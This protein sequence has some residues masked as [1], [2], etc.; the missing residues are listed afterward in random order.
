VP[1]SRRILVLAVLLI[2]LHAAVV[3]THSTTAWTYAVSECTQL[4]LDA[5]ALAACIIASRHARATTLPHTFWRLAAMS[6]CLLLSAEAMA[7]FLHWRVEFV[8]LAWIPDIIFVFWFA[9]L[10]MSLLLPPD[11]NSQKFDRLIFLDVFQSALFWLAVDIYFSHPSSGS[12]SS[13]DATLPDV[14][15]A[16]LYNGVIVGAFFLR[17]ISADSKSVR[18]LF[19]RMGMFLF[20]AGAADLFYTLSGESVAPTGWYELVWSSLS[21][22]P[23]AV[24]GSWTQMP[25]EETSIGAPRPS[26][27]L[28]KRQIFPLIYPLLILVMSGF[29]AQHHLEIAALVVV[30]SFLCSSIR[31]FIIQSRQARSER[32]LYHAKEF[33]ES[34]NRTKS[35]FLANMSHEIRTPMNGILGMADLALDTELNAEQRE[36]LTIVK[37]SADSLLQII[38]DILDFSK[39]EAGKMDLEHEPFS[40]RETLGHALKL[41]AVRAH[42][43]G[44]ELACRIAPDVPDSLSGDAGRLRQIVMN[45]VGNALKFT[46]SG[47]IVVRVEV[48]DCSTR[49]VLLNFQISDTGIGIDAAHQKRIFDA[50][51]QADGSTTRK[52]GGTGLGLT[53]SS[54]LVEL[55]G[56]HIRVDSELGK[57]TTF[58]FTTSFQPVDSAAREAEHVSAEALRDMSVLLVDDNETSR[59][60]VGEML[61]VW[62]MV[63]T[64]V[65]SGS[66]ALRR[67]EQAAS[68]GQ[69]YS[70]V[71]LDA[72]IPDVDSFALA[73]AIRKVKSAATT[74]MM[75]NSDQQAIEASRCREMGVAYVVK[76]VAQQELL[77]LVL[78]LLA[79]QTVETSSVTPP[80]R[81]LVR[82]NS[83]KLR[84]LLAE[85][86]LVNQKLAVRLL[87]KLGHRVIVANNGEQAVEFVKLHADEIDLVL[88]DVQMPKMNGLEATAA[89]R[90]L[91]QARNTHTPIIAMTA[92]AMKGDAERCLHAG[93][94]GYTSKPIDRA[95]L[96][97]E[98]DKHVKRIPA[99]VVGQL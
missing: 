85:D 26:N 17:A 5:L 29:I 53:I 43:Q 36:Y 15:T 42:Q 96:F 54:R 57:G 12:L 28:I 13:S 92:N 78:S 97:L 86:N 14:S 61:E 71:L 88:M 24:A 91:D 59:N 18:F 51:T 75:L 47:E 16:A 77:H 87:E 60:I 23:I 76:P 80:Q 63:P 70:I 22:V 67:S 83:P 35:E 39:V 31:V 82:K 68:A 55:M 40:L 89:I 49:T 79:P 10:S 65:D 93:M 3:A 1:G 64:L 74:V 44:L 11:F 27:D 37:S 4:G 99:T 48:A 81:T 6:F 33:A 56:G 94:D 9:P 25:L 66:A 7:A 34:A 8:Y 62:G 41:L 98:I 52:F 45:L 84:I 90:A 30:T 69:P 72:N 73:A 20:L 32:A 2:L 21:L 58:H 46:E 38:N 19:A 50:F 95:Q